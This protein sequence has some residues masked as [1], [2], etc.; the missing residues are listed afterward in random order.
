MDAE[1]ERYVQNGPGG[2]RPDGGRFCKHRAAGGSNDHPACRSFSERPT[3]DHRAGVPVR[4][5]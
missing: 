3:S 1:F 2:E 5:A 4:H